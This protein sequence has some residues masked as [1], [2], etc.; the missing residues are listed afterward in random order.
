MKEFNISL[1]TA[2]DFLI[3]NGF[4][5][6]KSTNQ[7]I[8]GKQYEIIENKFE[9]YR[10]EKIKISKIKLIE[11]EHEHEHESV[12]HK[13]KKEAFERY[14][15]F[16]IERNRLNKEIE[17]LNNKEQKYWALDTIEIKVLL[18]MKK[19]QL[20]ENLFNVEDIIDYFENINEVENDIEFEDFDDYDDA[21]FDEEIESKKTFVSN[22]NEW[23]FY[24]DRDE[25]PWV[26]VFGPGDEAE[27]A[28]WNTD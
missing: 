9:P 18:D 13:V 27:T 12:Y 5:I 14:E 26:D 7:K 10:N 15:E 8:D 4:E 28:Y 24:K 11:I 6:R 1:D 20:S 21:D 2:Y 17:L 19:Q 16:C 3:K 23:G 25:N 22:N